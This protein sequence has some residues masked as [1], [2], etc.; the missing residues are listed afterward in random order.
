LERAHL[1]RCFYG[2]GVSGSPEVIVN[3]AKV[4]EYSCHI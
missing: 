1:L 4:T 2:A 3:Y